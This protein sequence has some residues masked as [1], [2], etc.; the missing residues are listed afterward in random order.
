MASLRFDKSSGNFYVRFRFGGRPFNRSLET[1][2]PEQAQADLGRIKETLLDLKRGRFTVPAGAEPG[3]FI[4]TGGKLTGKPK[5]ATA[6]TLTRLIDLYRE[7][8]PPGA[9]EANSLA[10]VG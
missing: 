1:G 2:D 3:E 9:M 10:T 8:L 5:L 6:L 4:V 7:K